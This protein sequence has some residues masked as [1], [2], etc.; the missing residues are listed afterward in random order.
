MHPLQVPVKT[1]VILKINT[2]FTIKTGV[3]R[4]WIYTLLIVYYS[5]SNTGMNNDNFSQYLYQFAD[6]IFRNFI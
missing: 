4:K 6:F 1:K 3:T 2:T 5:V